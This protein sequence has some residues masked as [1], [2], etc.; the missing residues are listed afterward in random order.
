LRI[1]PDGAGQRTVHPANLEV[2]GGFPHE[3]GT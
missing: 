1:I 2:N 3:R